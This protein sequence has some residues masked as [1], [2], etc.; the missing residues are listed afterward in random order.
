MIIKS[1][2]SLIIPFSIAISIVFSSISYC[3]TSLS[4]VETVVNSFKIS[5]VGHPQLGHAGAFSENSFPHSVQVI[6]AM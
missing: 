4:A 6:N 3:G 2:G 1:L 5:S